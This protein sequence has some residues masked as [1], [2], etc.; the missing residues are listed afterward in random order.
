MGKSEP[1]YLALFIQYVTVS[2]NLLIVVQGLLSGG[3]TSCI[4]RR[5]F[6]RYRLCITV[7]V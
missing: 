7:T 3:H 2:G 5:D 1:N 6:I 4:R